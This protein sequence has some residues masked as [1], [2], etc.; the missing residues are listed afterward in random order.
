MAISL[1]FKYVS[2]DI[3]DFLSK[4]PFW[5]E[6]YLFPYL[7]SDSDLM[8][9]SGVIMTNHEFND[10]K[11]EETLQRFIKERNLIE[12][13]DIDK[14]WHSLHLVLT[15]D[16][17]SWG[18]CS[19]PYITKLDEEDG[20]PLVN[21]VMGG[22][23]IKVYSGDI[24]V[25]YL[26]PDEVKVVSSQLSL[27]ED[28]CFLERYRSLEGKSGEIYSS[29]WDIGACDDLMDTFGEVSNYYEKASNRDVSMLLCLG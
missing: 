20:Y 8:S 26:N 10:E 16:A 13:L 23:E 18:K 14:S 22:Q 1:S 24:S 7:V 17:S 28:S 9:C 29:S 12:E 19:L 2:D 5:I 15:K 3:W 21:A 27:I 6:H 25:H 4:E 11:L